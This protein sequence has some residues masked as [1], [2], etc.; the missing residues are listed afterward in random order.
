MPNINTSAK[1]TL[2]YTPEMVA[3]YIAKLNSKSAGGPDGLPAI[4]YKNTVKLLAFP[5]SVIFNL[6]LQT[7]VIPNVWKTAAIIPAFKKGSPSDPSNYRPISLTCI[8][9]KLMECGIKDA[10]ILYCRDHGIISSAQH[11]FLAKNP[12]LLS[13]WNV[14]WIGT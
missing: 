9:C 6:S 1:D 10:L 2:F 11:G 3:K 7:G 5:L 4:F 12:L 14:I 13:F 8:A